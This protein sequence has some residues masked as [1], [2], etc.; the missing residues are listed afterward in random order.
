MKKGLI[1]LTSLFLLAGC[2]LPLPLKVASWALDGV[3]Y[4]ATQKSIAENGLSIIAKKDCSL[5]R[6]LK[7]QPICVGNNYDIAQVLKNTVASVSASDQD[8]QVQALAEFETAAGPAPDKLSYDA[9]E[10][11]DAWRF[12]RQQTG[13]AEQ[14]APKHIVEAVTPPVT[15][16]GA[17]D[18][19]GFSGPPGYDAGENTEAWAFIQAR[20]GGLATGPQVA[21]PEE[22]QQAEEGSGDVSP[23]DTAEPMPAIPVAQAPGIGPDA[24]PSAGLYYVIG[25]LT[26]LINLDRLAQRQTDL[27]SLVVVARVRDRP[28][29]REVVGPF[30]RSEKQAIRRIIEKAGVTKAWLTFIDPHRWTLASPAEI[31]AMPRVGAQTASLR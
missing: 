9:S 22:T 5:M 18:T 13:Q 4:L 6:P 17:I 25:S 10:F 20:N 8:V 26:R 29:Y 7:G 3:S 15:A 30:K 28:I 1:V 12:M 23:P 19:T 14:M 21:P 27:E 24:Q 2:A 11:S 16:V 31:S